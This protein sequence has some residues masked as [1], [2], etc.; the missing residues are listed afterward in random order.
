MAEIIIHPEYAKLIEEINKLKNDIA[1]LFEERDELLYHIC[2]DIKVEYML[3]IGSLEYKAFQYQCKILRLRK[4]I[5][6]IQI[7][8]NREEEIDYDEIEEQLDK[9]FSEYI[10]KL[11]KMTKDIEIAIEINSAGRLTEELTREIKEIYRR[12]VKKL[13][14][15]LNKNLTDQE[16]DL[17]LKATKAYEDADIDTLRTIEILLSEIINKPDIEIDEFEELISSKKKYEDIRSS[18]LYKISEIKNS[19]PYNQK[20]LLEDEILLKKRKDDLNEDIKIYEEI[21]DELTKIL[22][23]MKGV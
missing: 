11:N 3:K 10:K 2:K 23:E 12:I 14:P 18:I 22:E 9:E 13:H 17:F 16:K 8:L 21:Y 6:L 20:E 5:M 7:K 1:N 19:F 15:D 4:K